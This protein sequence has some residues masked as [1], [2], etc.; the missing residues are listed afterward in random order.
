MTFTIDTGA[1]KTV[2]SVKTYNSFPQSNGPKLTKTAGGMEISNA[3][4]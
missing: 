2:I 1:T 3:T 4:N